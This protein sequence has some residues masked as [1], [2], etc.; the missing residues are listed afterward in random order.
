MAGVQL[1][2]GQRARH[3]IC[4]KGVFMH[5]SSLRHH[6]R[7]GK[8]LVFLSSLLLLPSLV[9]A[10]AFTCHAGDVGCIVASIAKGNTNL[11]RQNTIHLMPGTYQPDRIDNDPGEG[12]NA[13]PIITKPLRILG[14]GD[15]NQTVIQRADTA[16]FMRLL[17]VA[18]T[19]SLRLEGLTLRNGELDRRFFFRGGC[20]L[21]EGDPL[22]LVDVIVEECAAWVGGA[23]D[24]RGAVVSQGLILQDNL[25]ELVGAIALRGPV[26]QRVVFR[27]CWVSGNT[28]Q[29]E[30]GIAVDP[31]AGNI[32]IQ[33]CTIKDNIGFFN[34]GG[35]VGGLGE[36]EF[37]RTVLTGNFGGVRGGAGSFLEGKVTMRQVTCIDNAAEHF[38]G[39]FDV[40]DAD[41]DI[42]N[43]TIADNTAGARF[44]GQ[45]GGIYHQGQGRVTLTRTQ[46]FGN[47][48]PEGPDCFGTIEKGPGTLIGDPTGCTVVDVSGKDGLGKEV[49]GKE[50]KR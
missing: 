32:L 45:G 20:L 49:A 38:G 13:F 25:S 21:S 14:A 2:Q 39:C 18:A 36:V 22:V 5:T 11:D 3:T 7:Y 23:I 37:I 1:S 41:V 43:S 47:E 8:L 30:A 50:G 16:P 4:H 27:D 34:E 48:A 29:S 26:R 9:S 17:S 19:G 24:Q 12:A 33:G 10:A 6:K 40:R 42:E 46:L 44:G 15:P 28:A 31:S 35:G